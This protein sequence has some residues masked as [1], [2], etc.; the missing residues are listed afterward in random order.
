MPLI[1]VTLVEGRNADQLRTLITA[2]TAAAEDSLGA[3]KESI[4]VVVRELPATH[5][6]A[7]D[8]TIAERRKG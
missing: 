1:D 3:P 5:W 2:L 8:V 6:A 7:G 4:R